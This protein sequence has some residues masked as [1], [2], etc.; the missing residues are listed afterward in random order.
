MKTL[1]KKTFT[2]GDEWLYYKLYCGKQVADTILINAIL[3]FVERVKDENIISSWFFIRYN[4]PDFHIRLR[5]KI[6]DF[7]NF[8]FIVQKIKLLIEPYLESG[9]IWDVQIH[10]YKREVERYGIN[11]I[12]FV[13]RI[14]FKDSVTILKAKQLRLQDEE[15]ILF[16]IDLISVSLNMM[17]FS[18]SDRYQFAESGRKAF[19]S[20]FNANKLTIKQLGKKTRL[21]I[22][23]K[24]T[25]QNEY[26]SKL[27]ADYSNE[28]Y[29]AFLKIN[30][31]YSS[32]SKIFIKDIA[33]SIV[34]MSI[35]RYFNSN[36]R[37]YELLIYDAL[38]K[39]YKSYL[40]KS[41]LK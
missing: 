11:T 3:P 24:R 38:H 20:E 27:I 35:N 13:E 9:F 8:S 15:S 1:T 26:L 32:S 23:K 40:F 30:E 4:D 31:F 25:F 21:I 28:T 37:V 34:H 16:L 7:K 2:I 22:D 29:N 10:Q 5:L 19:T 36:Q 39:I 41:K 33:A 17:N 12:S 6:I 14:F 18:I